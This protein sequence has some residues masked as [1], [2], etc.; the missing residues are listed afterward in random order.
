MP[1]PLLAPSRGARAVGVRA[2]A[3]YVGSRL[4]RYSRRHRLTPCPSPGI[5]RAGGV[6][7]LRYAPGGTLCLAYQL[8]LLRRSAYTWVIMLCM[9]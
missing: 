5:L 2:P 8:D 4:L 9:V 1:P 7:L 3:V 6:H